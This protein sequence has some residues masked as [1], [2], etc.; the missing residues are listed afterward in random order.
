MDRHTYDAHI[1]TDI[2][3]LKQRCRQI[4]T[5]MLRYV[6]VGSLLDDLDGL[7]SLQ[8]STSNRAR[9]ANEVV[10]GYTMWHRW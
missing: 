10:G 1:R 3:R 7:E 5:D 2:E 8:G 9:A 4:Q 6:P